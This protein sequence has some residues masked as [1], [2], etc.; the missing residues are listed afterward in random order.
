MFLS[1]WSTVVLLYYSLGF[2]I[3]SFLFFHFFQGAKFEIENK[4][5]TNPGNT[6]TGSCCSKCSRLY[7]RINML[8]LKK[9]GNLSFRNINNFL[10]RSASTSASNVTLNSK[11]LLDQDFELEVPRTKNWSNNVEETR[12]LKNF[13]E[14]VKRF[15]VPTL[16]RDQEELDLCTTLDGNVHV[17]TQDPFGIHTF[18]GLARKDNQSAASRHKYVNLHNLMPFGKPC[19]WLGALHN[20]LLAFIP[21]LG[22]LI[23]LKSD[24]DHAVGSIYYMDEED[25]TYRGRMHQYGFSYFGRTR[26]AQ[27]EGKTPSDDWNINADMLMSQ[28]RVVIWR[29]G[30]RQ[31]TMFQFAVGGQEET[32]V[33]SEEQDVGLRVDLVLPISDDDG[34]ESCSCPSIDLWTLTTTSGQQISLRFGKTFRDPVT[35]NTIVND[36][37]KVESSE[38]KTKTKT[39]FNGKYTMSKSQ[40]FKPPSHLAFD[41]SSRY[42]DHVLDAY[43]STL[44]GQPREEGDA[45]WVYS[46]LRDGNKHKQHNNAKVITMDTFDVPYSEPGL[47]HSSYGNRFVTRTMRMENLHS[48]SESTS[49]ESISSESIS[50]EST[51][52]VNVVHYKSTTDVDKNESSDERVLVPVLEFVDTNNDT[53]RTVEATLP[54]EAMIENYGSNKTSLAEMHRTEEQKKSPPIISIDDFSSGEIVTLQSGGWVRLWDTDMKRLRDDL[55][56]WKDMHG[57]PHTFDRG[58]LEITGTDVGTRRKP[59]E[60]RTTAPDL[61]M[62]KHGKETDGKQHVGGNT[63]AGGTGGS[64]TAGLGGRGGPYRLDGG[65]EVH[66]VSDALKDEVTQETK[67][68]ARKMAEEAFQQRLDDIEL[69]TA[70][71]EAYESYFGRVEQQVGQLQNVLENVRA[72]AKERTWI[73]NSTHGE[74]DDAKIVD[75]AAGER[76]VYKRRGSEDPSLG[77]PQRKPKQLR[78]VFDVSGSMYRF[79]GQDQRLERMLETAVMVMTALDGMSSRF[80]Y[81]IVGHSG[82]GPNIPFVEV[83]S[84][85]KDRG[86]QLRILQR[87]VAHTQFCMSGD[88]T[89]QAAEY[90]IQEVS[91]KEGDEAF[92]FV[93]SDANLRRYGISPHE[94]GSIL[95]SNPDVNACAIFIASLADEA[96]RIEAALPA[97]TGHICFDTSDLPQ[98]FRNLFA[99]FADEL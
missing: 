59:G 57:R 70:E 14:E 80:E 33:E 56:I 22:C 32:E 4:A 8:M 67:L 40:P 31:L 3:F 51:S 72:M 19:A 49:N 73:K 94:L 48:S 23:R 45:I 97:G 47:Q 2:P 74:L 5:Y 84:P 12:A 34:I 77:T 88:T 1:T 60:E 75:G 55:A 10:Q 78:F 25:S 24:D 62:P 90:A 29:K 61:E 43:Y 37:E 87:M 98:L 58:S 13:S 89:L 18:T 92:V 52:I 42:G 93:V 28:R 30:K 69:G 66:Q 6:N 27:G 35:L 15:R 96:A 91:Q 20:D 79:N 64:N 41:S 82:D 50:N 11:F 7:C 54:A 68:R 81:S 76:N 21:E 71:N 86:D 38:T 53:L 95:T 17:L 46:S 65:H 83:G 85:P 44:V 99:S 26:G 63:W 39:K 36:D 9:I 16:G